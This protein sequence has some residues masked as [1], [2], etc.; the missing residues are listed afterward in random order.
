MRT[1]RFRKDRQSQILATLSSQTATAVDVLAQKL[2]VSGATIRADLAALEKQQR[3]IRTHGG[4]R[5]CEP[6]QNWPLEQRLKLCKKQKQAIARA[7][8]QFI[9]NG[10]TIALDASSTALAMVPFLSDFSQLTVVT[11]NLTAVAALQPNPRCQIVVPGGEFNP[12]TSSLQGPLTTLFLKKTPVKTVFFS[13]TALHPELG[14]LEASSAEA[15]VK[16]ALILCSR[17][18]VGLVDAS[19]WDEVA[20]FEIAQPYKL[21]ALIS[22]DSLSIHSRKVLKK[23]GTRLVVAS[24]KNNFI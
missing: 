8:C 23:T 12:E 6:L 5:K 7:A 2:G 16:K 10:D 22:D 4:A 1:Q 18:Q 17:Q 9:A 19:K 13:A 14:L 21:T 20:L 24:S 11:T 3:V 15:E